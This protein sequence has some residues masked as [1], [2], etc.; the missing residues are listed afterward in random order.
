MSWVGAALSCVVLPLQQPGH[1]VSP[2][3]PLAIENEESGAVQ[4]GEGLRVLSAAHLEV[5][6]LEWRGLKWL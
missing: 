6:I 5:Q 3:G 1:G 2:R 4:S